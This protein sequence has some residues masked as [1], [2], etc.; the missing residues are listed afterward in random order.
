MGDGVI[1]ETDAL[2]VARPDEILRGRQVSHGAIPESPPCLNFPVGLWVVSTGG[3]AMRASDGGNSG[4]EFTQE[5]W[6]VVGVQNIGGTTS[7]VEFVEKARYQ[8][9]GVAVG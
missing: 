7:K 3:G 8:G 1:S 9:G 2:C 6:G 4:H 5:F